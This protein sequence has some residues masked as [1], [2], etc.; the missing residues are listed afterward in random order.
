[1]FWFALFGLFILT[2]GSGG[3]ADPMPAWLFIGIW[4]VA[5]IIASY[6]AYVR[7][8][9]IV[10]PVRRQAERNKA[11]ARRELERLNASEASR[12]EGSRCGTPRQCQEPPQP[13]S[14]PT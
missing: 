1:M 2:S 7:H 3:T 11:A 13:R 14:K 10:G 9:A 12:Q 8:E 6:A 5:L 4:P